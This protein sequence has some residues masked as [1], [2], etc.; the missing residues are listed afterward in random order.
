[1]GTMQI[2]Y[3]VEWHGE[4][5]VTPRFVEHARSL[6]AEMLRQ[7][8]A[9]RPCIGLTGPWCYY[10]GLRDRLDILQ[11]LWEEGLRFT[12]ADGRNEH[13]RHPVAIDVHPYLEN[14]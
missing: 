1:M 12:R 14:L 9:G 5:D 11:V 4:G 6:H 2:G 7:G 10:R 8:R 3:D 13:D